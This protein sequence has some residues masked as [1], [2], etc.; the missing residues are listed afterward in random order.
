MTSDRTSDFVRAWRVVHHAIGALPI[1][2][3]RQSG[4]SMGA[5]NGLPARVVELAKATLHPTRN[6]MV[7]ASHPRVG[8]QGASPRVVPDFVAWLC[9]P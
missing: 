3:S 1:P 5:L 8:N 9:W 6:W 2:C 7:P 4:G